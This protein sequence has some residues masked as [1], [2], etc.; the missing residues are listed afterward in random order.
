MLLPDSVYP[1]ATTTPTDLAHVIL[2]RF[3]L[4]MFREQ[5]GIDDVAG[6]QQWVDR[7]LPVFA[8]VC[9]PSVVGQLSRPHRWLIG[10]DGLHPEMVEPLA[11]LCAPYPWVVLVEQGADDTFREPYRRAMSRDDVPTATHVLTT[12]LDCDDALALDYVRT[13]DAYAAAVLAADA[14]PD[15]FW[16]SFP[17]G[18]QLAKGRFRLYV[19]TTNHFLTR[20]VVAGDH[21]SRDATALAEAHSKVFRL[22]Q[23]VFLPMTS[24]PMWLQNVHDHNVL[25][26]V[27]GSF[28]LGP[29]PRLAEHFGIRLRGG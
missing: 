5:R 21:V 12:R 2:T 7:R 3:N 13:A 10:V 29:P 24:T 17:V 14:A 25:N 26:K 27:R 1:A 11:E 15:D 18:A 9:L 23:P 28:A 22:G 8:D 4:R 20:V 6:L 19:H 16:M